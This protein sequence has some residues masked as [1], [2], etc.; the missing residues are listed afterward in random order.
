VLFSPFEDHCA[1]M[2]CEQNMYEVTHD[3]FLNMQALYHIFS[4][5]GTS[6]TARIRALRGRGFWQRDGGKT[7]EMADGGSQ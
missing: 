2:S 1:A 3:F 7:A 6:Q 4:R 5:G